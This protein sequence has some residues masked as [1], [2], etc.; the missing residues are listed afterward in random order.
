[1]NNIADLYPLTPLQ[2][3]L[4]FH[5]L[6]A[7]EKGVYVNQVICRLRG[8][9]DSAALQQAWQWL[10]ERHAILRTAFVWEELETPLQVVYERVMLP[11]AEQDWRPLEDATQPAQLAQF[12]ETDRRRGVAL[13]QAP[14]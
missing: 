13:E 6:Y 7:P 12:L 10:L 11:W 2:E 8:E 3:G 4:L 9:V 5:A 1:M 14:L